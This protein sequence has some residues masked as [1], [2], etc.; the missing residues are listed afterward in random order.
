MPEKS[1]RREN[2]DV[3]RKRLRYRSWHRGTKEL[4]LLLG[5]FADRHLGTFDDGQLTLFEGLLAVP[6][7]EI[8]SWLVD[9][10]PPPSEAESDVLRLLLAHRIDRPAR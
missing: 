5:S 2:L 9:R 10:L 1:V 6:S 7:P 3:W 8:Q 4:D